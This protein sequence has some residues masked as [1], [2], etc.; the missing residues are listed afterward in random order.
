MIKNV[1]LYNENIKNVLRE[2]KFDELKNKSILITG[3][4]GLIGSAII[5]TLNYLNCH[6]NYNTKVIAIVRNKNKVLKRIIDYKNVI[7]LEQDV[8][9]KI[10]YEG[11]VDYIIHAASNAHPQVFVMDPVGTMLGNF[12]GMNN[13]LKFAISHGC[14]RVEY[15]SSGE[16]YGQ[17]DEAIEAFLEEYNGKI[18]PINVRS[19]Y[20]LSKLAAECLCISYSEQYN[21]ETVVARPCHIYGPTQTE[22]DSRASAQFIRNAVNG[23]NIIMKSEGLQVR[24]YCY[25]LDCVTGILTILIKG[26]DKEAYNV[27]NNNSRVSIKNIA[28]IIAKKS[29]TNVLFEIPTDSEKKG[30]NPVTRSVLDGEKLEKLGWKPFYT[31][32]DGIEQTINIMS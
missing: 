22:T 30:Y 27:A 3:A 29:N 24:S 32:E 7:I 12:I 5:D 9:E 18:N 15:I 4:N 13:I 17:G 10:K 26:G 11:N 16:V 2:N 28:N 31:I 21:I 8:I 25:V 20:P 23:E 14:K 6:E 1:N 19:C